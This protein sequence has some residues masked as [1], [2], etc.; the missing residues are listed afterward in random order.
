MIYKGNGLG[1]AKLRLLENFVVAGREGRNR[2]AKAGLVVAK[3][4]K[5]TPKGFEPSLL[6]ELT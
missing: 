3:I 6:T 1:N 4:I 2:K 5:T